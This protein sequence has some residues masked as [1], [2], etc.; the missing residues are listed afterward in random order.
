MFSFLR[1]LK[2]AFQDIGRNLS[3]S[4]MTVFIL[5]LML[6]SVNVLWSVDIITRQA[7]NSVKSQVDVSFYLAPAVATSTIADM[8]KYV[9]SFPEVTEVKI[10]TSDQVLQS[11]KERHKDQ[12]ESMQALTELGS[13]PFGSTLMVKTKEPK[14]YQKIIKA[15]DVP[16]YKK[17][18]ESKSFDK[19]ENAIE[20]LQKITNRI[21]QIGFGLTVLFAVISF[22][23]IFNTVRVTINSQRTEISIKRLVGASNWFIRGPYLIESL[24]FTALSIVATFVILVFAFGW[25]DSYLSVVFTGNFSL[26][27]YYKSNIFFLGGIQAAAVLLLTVVSSGLAMRRQLK[28]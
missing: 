5:V 26:T 6:L 18:I 14:D 8:E 2:F 27:N 15:L 12:I 28:V 17:I 1:I 21:E 4:F 11:F 9:K 25:L 20:R 16:E 3:L 13:N 19:H 23:I 22:L 7:V 10:L 24:L